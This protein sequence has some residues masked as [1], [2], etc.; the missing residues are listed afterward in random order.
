M[1]LLNRMLWAKL[2]SLPRS[3]FSKIMVRLTAEQFLLQANAQKMRRLSDLNALRTSPI[4]LNGRIRTIA[5]KT[6]HNAFHHEARSFA[7]ESGNEIL[8]MFLVDRISELH[9]L[10]Q[11][12]IVE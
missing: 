11:S 5:S 6:V 10:M 9:R 12:N 7:Q 1:P 3:L 4:D 2:D 8:Q